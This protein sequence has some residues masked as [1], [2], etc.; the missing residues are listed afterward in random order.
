MKAKAIKLGNITENLDRTLAIGAAA[1]AFIVILAVVFIQPGAWYRY[2][3]APVLLLIAS[4]VFLLVRRQLSRSSAPFPTELG[5][6]PS[7]YLILNLLFFG[8]FFYSILSVYLSPEL[9]QRPLSYFIST[10][11]AAAI[12][13]VEILFLPKGKA[14]TAFILLKIALITLS[15]RFMVQLIFPGLVGIDP[16]YHGV[17]TSDMLA[18]GHIAEGH[19]YS[20]LPVMHLLIGSTMLITNL[21]YKFAAMLSIGLLQ[22]ASFGFVFLL[23]RLV[24]SPKIGLLA[25][26]LLGVASSNIELGFWIR[27]VTAGVI[28]IP[29]L[30]YTAFKAREGGFIT[31]TS[32]VLLFSGVLI[33]T[34]SVAAMNMALFLFLFWLGFEIYK[35]IYRERFATPVGLTL[36]LIFTIAMFGWWTYE[37]GHIMTLAQLIGYGLRMELWEHNPTVSQYV[38]EHAGLELMVNMLGFTLYLA[39]SS[40]GLFYMFSRKL[41]TRSLFT[42]ALSAW[43]LLGMLFLLPLAGLSGICPGRWYGGLEFIVAIPSAIGLLWLCE[44][45]KNGLGKASVLAALVLVLCFMA[46]TRPNANIDNPIYSPNTMFRFAPIESEIKAQ[47]TFLSIYQG[48]INSDYS[49]HFVQPLDTK[50]RRPEFSTYLISGDYTGIEGLVMIR[51]EIVEGVCTIRG[52]YRLDHDPR[53]K[54]AALN[55]NCIY[56]SGTVTAFIKEE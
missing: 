10:A 8:L 13:A 45:F 48:H 9:Y 46:I 53:E 37:S 36:C 24:H 20:N 51:K 52:P 6:R 3:E 54:L 49:P 56:N 42:L 25:A 29:I 27:P 21:S 22:A 41:V 44:P 23:G 18:S 32:L 35:V 38:L 55:F 2:I 43:V 4:I 40:I 17:L 7:T 19:G 15:L 14:H 5:A 34:H 47:E 30:T 11:M 50:K 31:L 33:L 39:L 12:L 28:M 26:L 1:V 16:R